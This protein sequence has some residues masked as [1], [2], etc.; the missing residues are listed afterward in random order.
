MTYTNIITDNPSKLEFYRDFRCNY[1]INIEE[2]YLKFFILMRQYY[3]ELYVKYTNDYDTNYLKDYIFYSDMDKRFRYC[4]DILLNEDFYINLMDIMLNN[5]NYDISSA[6]DRLLMSALDLKSLYDAGH[7]LGLHSHS[8]PVKMELLNYKTQESEYKKNF[9]ILQNIV[10]P[11]NLWSASYPSGSY[12][13][14]SIKILDKLGIKICFCSKYTNCS[15][16][17]LNIPRQDHSILLE[18]IYENNSIY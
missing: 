13:N 2:F 7:I 4:R 11:G 18:Q 14:D 16:T 8:H 5:F 3:P 17:A 9:D 12:T 6:K 10:V 1:F 15:T